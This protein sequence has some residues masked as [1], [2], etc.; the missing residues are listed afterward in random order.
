MNEGKLIFAEITFQQS[1][2]LDA[3]IT[4]GNFVFNVGT[5]TAPNGKSLTF[6]IQYTSQG[7]TTLFGGEA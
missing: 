3:D 5:T 4:D 6:A 1:E 2:N 7:L